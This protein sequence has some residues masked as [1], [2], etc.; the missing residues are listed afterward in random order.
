MSY[1]LV[2]MQYDTQRKLGN[3]NTVLR[4]P[5]S[6][7]MPRQRASMPVPYMLDYSLYLQTK[8]LNDGWQIMEQI[9]PF[10]TPSYTVR[11]RHFPADADPET[12]QPTNAYD[13]P[14]TLTAVTWTDDWI[15]DIGDRRTIEWQLEFSTKIWLYG[16]VSE[17]TI[18]LDSR[19]VV[20]TPSAGES[21]YTMTRNTPQEGSEVGY[22]SIIDS[23]GA[24]PELED[25]ST[26]PNI[27][28]LSD[29]EGNIVK[30]IRDIDDI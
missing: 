17:S 21:V 15:G 2:A 27:L 29:S 25:D 19:A 12:P 11:V 5:D 18:I 26:S 28:N 8:N 23:D 3:K 6:L 13:I 1:E 16:P 10:F 14:F 9:L 24:V 4:T 22:A 7:D 20:A 30:I